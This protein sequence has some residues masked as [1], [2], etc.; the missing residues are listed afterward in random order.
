[1]MKKASIAPWLSV[2]NVEKVLVFYMAAFGADEVY[3][4]EDETGKPVVVHLTINEADFWI[5]EDLDSNFESTI[6]GSVRMI[7]TVENPDLVFQQALSAGA[8]EVSPVGEEHGWRI[9]HLIDPF[10]FHWEIGKPLT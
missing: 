5:Q 9:G 8:A 2:R 1:M 7:L 4:L 6:Q 10:G 3:R